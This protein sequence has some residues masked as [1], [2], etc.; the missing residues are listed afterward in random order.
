MPPA[1]MPKGIDHERRRFFST[2]AISLA[3]A[4]FILSGAAD[5]QPAGA[6]PKALP[7]TRPGTNTAFAPLKQPRKQGRRGPTIVTFA[8]QPYIDGR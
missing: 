3:A 1:Q 4:E 5:A 8:L 6:K 7:A 2:A